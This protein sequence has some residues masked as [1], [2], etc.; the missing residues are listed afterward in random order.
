MNQMRTAAARTAGVL[1]FAAVAALGSAVP[2]LA[3]ASP[4]EDQSYALQASGVVAVQQAGDATY[5]GGS[6]VM[7]PNVDAAGLLH[8]GPVTDRATAVSASSWLPGV[9]LALPGHAVL[10]AQAVASSCRYAGR[11][12]AVSGSARITGGVVQDGRRLIRLPA[13]AAP[14]TRI[15]I[16]GSAA[17][18]LNRQFT[19]AAGALT[20]AAL[21]IRMLR[22]RQKVLLATSVCAAADLAPAAAASGPV[23]RVAIGGLGLATLG[24]LAWALSRRR[25]RTAGWSP[26]AAGAGAG[27]PHASTRAPG[28]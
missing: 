25:Q 27:R 5:N 10:R 18:M 1:A 11:P 8:T 24:A 28:G 15:V 4:P 22:G 12:A 6:P 23:I 13:G 17:I 7:L 14:N 26:P 21:R 16:P 9:V 2:A 19:G 20:V 3:A